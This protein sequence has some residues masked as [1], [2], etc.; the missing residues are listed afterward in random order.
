MKVLLVDD[1]VN[2]R[3]ALR[4][5]IESYFP[6]LEI[7][8]EAKDLPEAVRK[9]NQLQ[10]DIVFLDIEMPGYSGLELVSFFEPEQVNFK[11]VFVTAYSE[12]ALQAF[13]MSA[14]DYLL[15]PVRREQIARA[16]EKIQPTSQHQLQALQQNT[17]SQ[18]ERRIGLQLG[19]GLLFVKLDQIMYLRADG[20]YTHIHLSDGQKLTVTKKL[21]EYEKL[22]QWGDFMRIHRS[23]IINIQHIAKILKQDG[24]TVI[25]GDG[26]SFPISGEKKQLFM[27]RFEH[28]KI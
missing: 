2:A 24:G 1:E 3:L 26:E 7:A 17:Q 4:G 8:D 19:D 9:I 15:K 12:Y 21:L 27:G 14:I 11:I 25:M 13:E 5:M 10:P 20:S 16:L 18:G 6:E 28:L 23:H 22:E